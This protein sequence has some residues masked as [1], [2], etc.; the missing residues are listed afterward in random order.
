MRNTRIKERAYKQANQQTIECNRHVSRRLEVK[1]Q[2]H[3]YTA[4]GNRC[5]QTENS[6]LPRVYPASLLV[7]KT[8]QIIVMEHNFPTQDFCKEMWKYDVYS[9]RHSNQG[10]LLATKMTVHAMRPLR[11]AWHGVPC[12][13]DLLWPWKQ[14]SRSYECDLDLLWPLSLKTKVT[15]QGQRSNWPWPFMTLKQRSRSYEC[16]NCCHAFCQ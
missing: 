7:F 5:Y 2:G 10:L 16:R 1:G 4:Y 11:N 13:L 6:R 15:F 9:C 14:R 3:T 8:E 12:D